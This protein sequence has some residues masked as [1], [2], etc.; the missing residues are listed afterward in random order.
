MINNHYATQIPAIKKALSGENVVQLQ[1]FF[2]KE[3]YYKLLSEVKKTKLK[4][5]IDVFE[6]KYKSGKISLPKEFE[7]FIS[8]ITGKK[9]KYQLIELEHK[10][11]SLIHDKK[12]EVIIDLS[13]NWLNGWGGYLMYNDGEGNVVKIPSKQNSVTISN[14]KVF[15]AIKYV[16]NHSGKNKKTYIIGR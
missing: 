5:D 2:D 1:E 16:N 11:Y 4:P 14:G 3:Y 6:Y 7:N 8:K 13:E 9:F 15:G 10:D 12:A